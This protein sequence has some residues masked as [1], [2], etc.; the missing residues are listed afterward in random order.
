MYCPRCGTENT[1]SADTCKT[2]GNNLRV[3]RG[4]APIESEVPASRPPTS[5]QPPPPPPEYTAPPGQPPHAYYPAGS[6]PNYL[7][8]SII[9]TLCCC[10]PAGIPAIVYAAQVNGKLQA[11]DVD[12]AVRA[13]K[14]A[15][16]WCW[17]AFGLGLAAIIVRFGFIGI[18]ATETGS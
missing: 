1:D 9:V 10:L 12:G 18:D 11:G 8:Q 5:A 2:C 14:N 7:V 6:I 16:T 17:V 4:E 13:S 3:W 15:R